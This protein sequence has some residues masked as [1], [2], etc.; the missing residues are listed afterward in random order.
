MIA[1]LSF[2]PT[3][4][5]ARV[6]ILAA[7][8]GSRLGALTADTHKSL[9]PIQGEPLL[10]RTLRQLAERGFGDV[11]IVVGHLR[12]S[13]AEAVEPWAE[14][15]RLVYNERFATDTNIR[16]LLCGLQGRLEKALIIE[17]DVAF[18]DAAIDAIA[19]ASRGDDSIWFT[20]GLFRS[21]QLGGILAVDTQE[22][23]TDLRYTPR[24]EAAFSHYRKLLGVLH[25]GPREIPAYLALLEQA[26]ARTT[27]QYFMMPWVDN[28]HVLPCLSR[29]LGHCR[30]ATFNTLEEYRRCR[31]LLEPQP[32]ELHVR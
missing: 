8:Q 29:D 2:M 14:N 20:S 30:T 17:G 13:I 6:V 27:A 9:L 25:V 4:S 26:A 10:V 22:R 18:D 32:E 12:E 1:S 24:Y 19:E 31:A 21:H 15:V 23:V 7:G 3:P 11:T 5:L 16:S 28:L